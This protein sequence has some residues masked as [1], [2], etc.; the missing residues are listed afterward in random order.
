MLLNAPKYSCKT[1]L[2]IDALRSVP[3]LRCPTSRPVSGALRIVT[4]D[5]TRKPADPS[6]SQS[7]Q[8]LQS[9]HDRLFR[10]T[11]SDAKQA[12]GLLAPL[13]PQALAEQIDWSSLA[14]ESGSYVDET[15]R[16]K[17]ADLLFSASCN[18]RPALL[19]LLV[20]HQSSHDRFMALR[21]LTYMAR[22]LEHHVRQ[23]P[24]TS[25][26]PPVIPMVVSNGPGSWSPATDMHAL[27]DLPPEGEA[28][29]SQEP[30]RAAL[31][32]H[33]PSFRYLVDD[34]SA[35][36]EESIQRRALSEQATLTL[37][38]LRHIRNLS[39]FVDAL[40]RWSPLLRQ[41]DRRALEQLL[42]YILETGDDPP[43]ALADVLRSHVTAESS[44]V[45]MSTAERLRQEGE[46]RGRQK[47]LRDSLLLLLREQFKQE[48]P[49]PAQARIAAASADELSQWL[50][51]VLSA[52]T[53]SD[54]FAEND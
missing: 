49:G 23:H 42:T 26:L 31:L 45:A 13:I 40:A 39:V 22:I 16:W 2:K 6:K 52:P 10:A 48:V 4:D 34:L 12:A 3:Y 32:P 15:L 5:T 30:V 38:A 33:L 27:F 24:G 9:P 11:F 14:L 35:A 29:Q 43:E 51:R 54:V 25:H 37:L 50:T 46:A 21:L 47:A 1:V 17:H 28:S 53:I 8:A 20:E 18:G 19:Y 44:E 7:K 36:S 41:L